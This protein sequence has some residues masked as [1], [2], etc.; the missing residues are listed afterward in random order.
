MLT[1]NKSSTD[2]EP[3]PSIDAL[4]SQ[5]DTF[6]ARKRRP[7]NP[8]HW[9]WT[10]TWTWTCSSKAEDA[11]PR[12][13]IHGLKAAFE[14]EA[15]ALDSF[16]FAVACPNPVSGLAGTTCVA[17]VNE[18]N[19]HFFSKDLHNISIIN[20]SEFNENIG[21]DSAKTSQNF[22][23][24]AA[25]R[26][27]ATQTDLFSNSCFFDSDP[28]SPNKKANTSTPF[29]IKSAFKV[30]PA[31]DSD[32]WSPFG[33]SKVLDFTKELAAIEQHSPIKSTRII[34]DNDDPFVTDPFECSAHF[35]GNTPTMANL[36]DETFDISG[37][38][39]SPTNS[40]CSSPSSEISNLSLKPD[41]FILNGPPS[42]FTSSTDP[43]LFVP[44]TP[45]AQTRILVPNTPKTEV[46][47]VSHPVGTLGSALYQTILSG[48]SP[49][50]PNSSE[51]SVKATPQQ[52]QRQ[53]YTSSNLGSGLF[54]ED[55]AKTPMSRYFAEKSC[56]LGGKLGELVDAEE[57]VCSTF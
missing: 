17:A 2:T 4:F 47:K 12:R 33:K 14:S 8:V 31:A 39:F 10:W 52:Q 40:G 3:P 41:D 21:C 25:Q 32:V 16:S 54:D 51:L 27:D 29:S 28:F 48:G 57:R 44:T 22:V 42:S 9:T 45:S 43:T 6:L 26:D 35:T 7:A 20:H 53:N 15:A 1:A 5:I 37:H 49:S 46:Y 36:L 34:T 55:C 38:D 56:K 11:T 24:E 23:F 19:L 50:I 30:K 18:Q 13:L